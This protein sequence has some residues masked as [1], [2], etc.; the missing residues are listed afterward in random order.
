VSAD[1]EWL[2]DHV[3]AIGAQTLIY[4]WILILDKNGDWAEPLGGSVEPSEGMGGES[5]VTIPR[6]SM[7]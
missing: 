3:S 1:A 2:K 4:V 7:W 5:A 6:F